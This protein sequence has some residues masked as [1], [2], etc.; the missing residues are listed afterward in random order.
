MQGLIKRIGWTT[1]WLLL[2]TNGLHA[3][4]A[5]AQAPDTAARRYGRAP[6]TSGPSREA[7]RA[8]PPRRADSKR[9]TTRA[10]R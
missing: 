1:V 4:P 2:A 7:E 6:P 10:E 8:A 5:R 3:A 9:R